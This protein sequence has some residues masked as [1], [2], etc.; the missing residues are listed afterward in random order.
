[1]KMTTHTYLVPRLIIRGAIPSLPL[2]FMAWY[3]LTLHYPTSLNKSTPKQIRTGCIVSSKRTD[4]PVHRIPATCYNNLITWNVCNCPWSS[5]LWNPE[6]GHRHHEDPPLDS[7]QNEF[8]PVYITDQ[9]ADVVTPGILCERGSCQ[10]CRLLDPLPSRRLLNA[11]LNSR[12]RIENRTTSS[13]RSRL[14]APNN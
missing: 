5:L 2:V 3:L 13:T 10:S 9:Q 11:P 8:H 4:W 14:A 12:G 6:Y 1:M 7:L